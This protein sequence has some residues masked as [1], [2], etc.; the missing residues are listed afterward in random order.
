MFYLICMIGISCWLRLN[1]GIKVSRH[2]PHFGGTWILSFKT[3][4]NKNLTF[5]MEQKHLW[6]NAWELLFGE[7]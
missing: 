2:V 7:F 5:W 3:K 1:D 4:T 6:V